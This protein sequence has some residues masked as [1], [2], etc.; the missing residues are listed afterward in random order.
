V[1]KNL[2]THM[3][4]VTFNQTSL[5]IKDKFTR[6]SRVSKNLHTHMIKVTF[7]QCETFKI[8]TM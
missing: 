1:F 8:V 5:I 6:R 3:I 4:E 2:H 7:N